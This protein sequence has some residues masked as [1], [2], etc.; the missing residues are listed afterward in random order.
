[1]TLQRGQRRALE[2]LR[3]IAGQSQ[4]GVQ[5]SDA[6]LE[7]T[8][9][10]LDVAVSIDCSAIP[11]ADAGIKLRSR[12]RV[13]ISIGEGFPYDM[14]SVKAS[15]DRWAGTPHVQW[16]R[17]MCLYQAVSDWDVQA[18]MYGLMDRLWLWLQ[19]AAAGEL[20]PADAPLHPP[21]VLA[22]FGTPIIVRH[23]T[24]VI[25]DQPWVGFAQFDVRSE[26]RIDLV[27]W[28]DLDWPH[29]MDTGSAVAVLLSDPFRWEYPLSVPALLVALAKHGISP[30]LLRRLLCLGAAGRDAG[31]PLHFV[32]GTPMRRGPD[33][34]VRQHLAVW[35]IPATFA[36]PLRR[37][38]NA[39]GNSE[40]ATRIRK[41]AFA[42]VEQ[43][44]LRWCPISE[45]RP[46]I[47]V[48]RDD[49]SPLPAAFG[50][51]SVAVF[52]CG[53]IGAHVAEWIAR[54][55]AKRIELYDKDTV[56]I[57]ILVRQPFT[58][59]DIGNY[60]T[61]VLAERLKAMRPDLEVVTING[62]LIDGKLA[63]PDWHSD[64][65]IVIDATASSA[66][67]LRLE[68]ARREHPAPH[69]TLCGLL[70]G[71][72]AQR[73]IAVTAPPGYSGGVEDV[74]RQAR[75]E[76]S[77]RDE[78][79]AFA[80]EFWPHER[81]PAFQ[82]EPGCSDPTFR[83]AC[84][85]VVALSASLLHAVA[86]DITGG[87]GSTASARLFALPAASH[88]GQRSAHLSWPAAT[89]FADSVGDYEIRLAAAALAEIRGWITHSSRTGHRDWET[90]GVLHGRRDDVTA[91]VWIDTASGPPPD[92]ILSAQTFVCGLEGVHALS[93]ERAKRS[94]GELAYLGMWHTHPGMT[95]HPSLKDLSGMLGLL[96]DDTMR[97][98]TMLIVG[99]RPGAE[100]LAGYV[101]ETGELQNPDGKVLLRVSPRPVNAPTLP[102]DA[103]RDIGLA[104]SGGGAR[105]LAFHLGCLRALNDR[106]LL[107]RIRVV[108]GVS[109][110][111]LMTGLYAYGPEHFDEFD[112]RVVDI[113]RRGTQLHIVQRALLSQRLP[114][115]LATRVAVGVPS[116]AAAAAS[117][118]LGRRVDAPGR[119]WISRTDGFVDV[120]RSLLGEIS[121]DS[122]RHDDGLDIVINACDLRSGTAFRF[123]SQLTSSSRWGRLVDTPDLATAIAASA[124]YPLLLPTLDRSWT[125]EDRDG[126]RAEHRV[127]LTDGGVYDNSGTSCLLPGRRPQH[128]EVVYDV[129]YV[130]A[131]DAGRGQ[132]GDKYPFHMVPR[133]SRAF[134]ASFRKLQDASRGALHSH[135]S[136]GELKGFVMPYLGQQDDRLPWAPADLVP[137]NVV[138]DYPTNF[139]AMSDNALTAI[140]TRGEQLTR[141]LIER[142][143]PELAG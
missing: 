114:E 88:A 8:S 76:C 16:G 50:G 5:L 46:E 78:L 97:E 108:S 42:D 67:R 96:Y 124:A 131:C 121:L 29:W 98:A 138:A 47:V 39:G 56:T 2:Q 1:M 72:D 59:A 104:L 61:A 105:A 116:A 19:R 111:A 18:G 54:A 22:V 102:T 64:C 140:T 55:G 27:A 93:K 57:G 68:A 83:G 17:S 7:P 103:P 12:E 10:T 119:R 74:L 66:V 45:D 115:D 99:G 25:T 122:P 21:A 37:L 91:I 63:Q 62:N 71:H 89:V 24:P 33:G 44:G 53:A 101:F 95:A 100:E 15:H 110:G 73:A 87:D 81:K 4:G 60:K 13:V 139:R 125:F 92:S 32:L 70:L 135:N 14:P 126:H 51:R 38:R 58:D 137:R 52:G 65:D 128:T 134:E 106:D 112:A 40:E 129:D 75:L 28:H 69:T 30:D 80:D 113:L 6:A 31:E 136:H 132:L 41:E 9:P 20:D 34:S 133:I 36:D 109:G 141:V 127:L 35:E 120:L 84:T 49:Q 23:D 90:G 143:C 11:R 43:A 3:A 86:T 118:L 79:S 48:R 85:D 26:N 82:P 107:K 117:K 94:R 77:L 142:W 123:G 130:I